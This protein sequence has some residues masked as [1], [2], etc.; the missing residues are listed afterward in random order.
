MLTRP[1]EKTFHRSSNTQDPKQLI[2]N[3]QMLQELAQKLHFRPNTTVKAKGRSSSKG[4]QNTKR[5]EKSRPQSKS[6]PSKVS[7][8]KKDKTGNSH[9]QQEKQQKYL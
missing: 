2:F 3:L 6:K 4:K 9:A 7:C 8:S 5:S 1:R